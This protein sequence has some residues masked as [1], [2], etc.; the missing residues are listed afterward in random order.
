MACG[1]L[2]LDSWIEKNAGKPIAEIFAA[3][4]EAA[5]RDLEKKAVQKLKGIRNHVISLGSGTVMD[6]SSWELGR[7]LGTTVWIDCPLD[8]LVRRLKG[9]ILEL[10]KRPLLADV[11]KEA[12]PVVRERKLSERLAAILGQRK[13]R[14]A[15]ADISFSES[16]STPEECARRIKGLVNLRNVKKSRTI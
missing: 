7:S 1:F 6:A 13:S 4:G 11:I 3:D 16:F 15:E 5:F 12:D 14:F 2:D 9:S 8:E 10:E